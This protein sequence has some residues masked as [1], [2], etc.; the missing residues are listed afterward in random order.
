MKKLALAA[1]LLCAPAAAQIPRDHDVPRRPAL[2]AQADT[3]NATS[4]YV[5]GVSRL[6][7][8]PREA[9]AAFYWAARLRPGWADPLYGRRVA[10]LMSDP[11]RLVRY[12]ADDRNTL[13]NPEILAIDS[14]QLQALS[15]DPFLIQKFDRDLLRAYM[16]RVV[17]EDL[18]EGAGSG[19]AALA[20][21]YVNNWLARADPSW[22]AWIAYSE[23][24]FPQALSEYERTLARSNPRGRPA[25]QA[26]LGRIHFFMG[27]LDRAAEQ[28]TAAAEGMRKE[29]TR[30]L[31]RVYRSKALLEH[32][33]GAV[34]Q[35][36]GNTTAAQEAYGRALQ[37]DLAFA[38]AHQALSALAM[39]RGDS[40]TAISEMAL[41]VELRPADAALRMDYGMMLVLAHKP[42][43]GVAE[44]T[45]ATEL[46]PL[47]AA[48]RLILARLYDQSGM[49][50]EALT[51]YQAYLERAAREDS[52][53]AG[54][55]QRATAL[56]AEP[57]P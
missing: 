20:A 26:D 47:Y 21:H 41:A 36:M 46:E 35:K 7:T 13:R 51:A 39:A 23:G 34:Y 24:R 2:W 31:V 15:L 56:A 49:G 45:R 53:Y 55:R 11:D 42:E 57:K 33:L 28:F 16:T 8:D 12:M 22:R 27:N 38:P 5:H 43:L 19:D 54:A 25:I 37:E 1:V 48:P 29:D 4:Y 52:G 6:G 9:A 3:N 30:D 32:S 14:L 10:L 44:L 40:A 17:T 18:R 50:P